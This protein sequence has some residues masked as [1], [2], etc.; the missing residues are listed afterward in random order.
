MKK[1]TL[2]LLTVLVFGALI[3]LFSRLSLKPVDTLIRPPKVQGDN[4]AIQLAFENAILEKYKLK[5]PLSGNYNSSYIFTDLNN[6]EVSE[7]VI[8]YAAESTAD[9]VRMNVLSKENGS[10]K[11]IADFES[12]HNEVHQVNFADVDNDG[13]SEII[14]GWSIYDTELS[15]TVNVFKLDSNNKLG[16]ISNIFTKNYLEFS[17]CDVNGDKTS[18][19]FVLEKTSPAAGTNVQ[20]NAKVYSFAFGKEKEISSITLDPVI[21]SVKTISYDYDELYGHSHIYI[22]GYKSDSGM[23]TDMFYWDNETETLQRTYFDENNTLSAVAGRNM[24][25]V[26][27]DFNDDSVIEIPFEHT[28]RSSSLIQGENDEEREQNY[29]RWMKYSDGEFSEVSNQ[30]YNS[31]YGYSVII[32]SN[33]IDRVTVEN[34]ITTGIM[35]FYELISEERKKGKKKKDEFEYGEPQAFPREEYGEPGGQQDYET[36]YSVGEPLFSLFAAENTDLEL[37]EMSGYRFIKTSNKFNY[38]Y[39]LYDRGKDLGIDKNT[40]KSII[41]T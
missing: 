17:V 10:W 29:I 32:S 2:K 19:I 24:N 16:V 8:F 14:V 37:Y 35:T 15:N 31:A 27:T 1:R 28:L 26:C 40:V 41:I 33:W 39:Q 20:L 36:V 3:A 18:D 25:I 12:L 34:D 30:I 13:N 23:T 6:D 11:S 7:A 21:S 38:Y 22:D 5:N 9:V 4:A